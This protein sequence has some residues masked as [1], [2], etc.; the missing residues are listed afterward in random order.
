MTSKQALQS[1]TETKAPVFVEIE[2][3]FAQMK[4]FTE[5]IAHRAYG[6]FEARGRELGHELEDWVRAETELIRHV[7]VEIKDTADN[8]V[9]RAEVPGFS[10]NDLKVSVEARQL[11]LSGKAAAT[12]EEKTEQ[13]IY[14][15]RRSQQF[16]RTVTLPTDVEA[17]RATASLRDGVLELILPKT[18]QPATINVTVNT[19]E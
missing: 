4:D 15:E 17:T 3:I 9:I 19:T 5:S 13:A 14:N 10:A 11:M 16:Y 12:T 2:K 8:L 1:T 18:A 6:F 7:P